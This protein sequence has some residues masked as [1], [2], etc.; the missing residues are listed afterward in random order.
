MDEKK[1]LKNSINGC[2]ECPR[3]Y[4]N[5]SRFWQEKKVEKQRSFND[6]LT[7]YG[8]PG[9]PSCKIQTL[10]PLSL[11]IWKLVIR[12]FGILILPCDTGKVAEEAL[13]TALR[14]NREVRLSDW[15]SFP[16]S[17]HEPETPE[18]LCFSRVRTR[19][20]IQTDEQHSNPGENR[21]LDVVADAESG[22]TLLVEMK[23]RKDKVGIVTSRRLEQQRSFS[24][25]RNYL[26]GV[27]IIPE[28]CFDRFKIYFYPYP[29]FI[30][31][32]SFG[33]RF[34]RRFLVSKYQF[35]IFI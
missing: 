11:S 21:E 20:Y 5:P 3:S 2:D 16:Q 15:F 33:I 17:D 7:S 10:F 30:F 28:F 27:T 32:Y 8:V 13:A 22:Q 26:V 34:L 24:F 25:F 29:L 6:S 35:I 23:K 14:F 9:I 12:E 1:S 4:P 18:S 31:H 19:L